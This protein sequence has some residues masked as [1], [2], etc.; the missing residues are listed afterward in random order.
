MG[1]LQLTDFSG[2]YATDLDSEQMAKDE[3]LT[4]TN[5]QWRNKIVKRKGTN[6]YG[7]ADVSS[8]VDDLVGGCRVFLNDT[9]IF[10]IAKELTASGGTPNKVRLYQGAADSYAV[11]T[12]EGGAD[13]DLSPNKEVLFSEAVGGAVIAVNGTD[14]PTVIYWDPDKSGGAFV[15]QELDRYDERVRKNSE[16]S[17]GQFTVSGNV[18]TVDTDDAQNDDTADFQISS[19]TVND[20][21]YVAS[22]YPFTSI[23]YDT[24]AGSD[25]DMNDHVATFEY[26]NGS[27]WTIIGDG[28][29]D[30]DLREAWATGTKTAEFDIP[31]DSDGVIAW[32]T[33]PPTTAGGGESASAIAALS[34]KYAIR[35]KFTTLDSA[36]AAVTC[37]KISQ[38]SHTHF[39]TEALKDER[40][41]L[42][43][44]HKTYP[45]LGFGNNWWVGHFDL[46]AGPT[47]KG[48]RRRNIETAVEG[49]EKIQAMVS[50]QDYLAIV[51]SGAIYGMSGIFVDTR[52]VKK[53]ANVGTSSGPSVQ[54][55][56]DMLMFLGTDG[57]IY[58]WNG[59]SHTTVST[60]I[61]TDLDSFSRTKSPVAT[62]WQGE[63]WLSFPSSEVVITTDPD[64]FRVPP[65]SNG[66]G[67][68]SFYKFTSYRVDHFINV[69]G[70]GE[71]TIMLIGTDRAGGGEKLRRLDNGATDQGSA[72]ITMTMKTKE[73]SDRQ[74]GVHHRVGRLKPSIDSGNG[75]HTLTVGNDEGDTSAHTITNTTDYVTPS[76][77][78]DGERMFLQVVH[79]G[80]TTAGVRGFAVPLYPRR[81]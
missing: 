6:Q 59:T 62:K 37:K 13:Y 40:P 74:Y 80:S 8:G 61:K 55:V 69:E 33:Y 63:Y 54:V 75:N 21:H 48:W 51:K 32:E 31:L 42:V 71:S 7:S 12:D 56:K 41:H 2:G 11:I 58:M 4:A 27:G 14:R 72:A 29:W 45:V 81:F 18:Y 47:V 64:S 68:V 78:V 1:L 10:I 24:I 3:L 53:L 5:C 38:I 52:T 50:H 67:R 43:T 15:A 22:S 16:W 25:S 35:V 57:N 9:W 79:N 28:K 70:A 65:D 20:G 26:W 19:T 30:Q 44:V 17:A 39:L 60:H 73:F 76:Y 46:V 23:T 66:E 77:A 34:T 49:G 36:G